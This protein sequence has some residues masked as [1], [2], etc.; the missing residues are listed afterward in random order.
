MSDSKQDKVTA[1]DT[2]FTN[3]HIQK[4]KVLITYL[5]PSMQRNMAIYIKYLEL[6]HTM[7]FFRRYPASAMPLPREPSMDV[8]RLCGEMIPYCDDTQRAQM[9][10]MQNMF[11][12]F[13][14]YK[15]M[16]EMVQM[17]K[18][19]FPEGENPLNGLFGGMDM[20][21]MPGMGQMPDME[22]MSGM[23]QMPDMS[24]IFE[25]FQMFNAMKGDSQNGDDK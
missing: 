19:M 24:Q 25:M 3:N 12:T 1:F 14:N 23:G 17:M 11:R 10:N 15:E 13:E 5:D 9:E 21:Q 4:L 16:M 20:S 7:Y 6:Q 18:E 22:Q 2:L 8:S